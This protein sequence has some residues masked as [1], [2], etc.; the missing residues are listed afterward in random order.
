MFCF[1][2]R[3]TEHSLDSLFIS[4]AIIAHN[5]TQR[6]YL[7]LLLSSEKYLSCPENQSLWTQ[8]IKAHLPL[9]SNVPLPDMLMKGNKKVVYFTFCKIDLWQ[10]NI[11]LLKWFNSF[12]RHTKKVERW[13]KNTKPDLKPIDLWRPLKENLELLKKS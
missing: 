6:S 7:Q 9:I 12:S 5:G 11:K 1:T 8:R 2:N 13:R 10:K 4:Q 3:V